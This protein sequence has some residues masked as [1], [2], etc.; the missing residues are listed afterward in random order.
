MN[1]FKT[2]DMYYKNLYFQGSG[3]FILLLAVYECA[4]FHHT[5]DNIIY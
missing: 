5:L 3:Q 2:S 4:Y 1:I